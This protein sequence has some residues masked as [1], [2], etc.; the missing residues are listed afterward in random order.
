MSTA[1]WRPPMSRG[2]RGSVGRAS[3][4]PHSLMVR[5]RQRVRA[6]RGPMINSTASRTMKHQECRFLI[7]RDARKSALLRMRSH[8]WQASRNLLLCSLRRVVGLLAVE[9]AL[10]RI[11]VPLRRTWTVEHAAA[12]DIPLGLL[13]HGLGELFQRLPGPHRV[14]LHLCGALGIVK[15]VIGVGDGGADRADAV[16]GHEQYRLVADH[17]REARAFGGI[18]RRA[19]VF[20]VIGNLI[21]QPDLGLAD[22][23]DA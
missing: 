18:E 20:V 16:I 8:V 11:E 7:L 19:G 21:H 23:L 12:A 13:D 14:D 2:S 22:L 15:P 5:S 4:A 6:K 3:K 17:S 10:E 1:P 9:D